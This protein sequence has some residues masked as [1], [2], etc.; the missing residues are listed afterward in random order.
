M[1]GVNY[2]P[3]V[4]KKPSTVIYEIFKN[5]SYG[6]KELFKG[7]NTTNFWQYVASDDEVVTIN[8]KEGMDALSYINYL[9]SCMRPLGT[10]S[11][12]P[13]KNATYYLSIHDDVNG[14]YFKVTKVSAN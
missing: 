2:F 7:M 1:G 13:I 5:N 10:N 14:Q 4:V 3:K 12:S 9:V 8:A 11:D 6:I